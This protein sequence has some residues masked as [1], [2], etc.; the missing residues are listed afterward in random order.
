MGPWTYHEYYLDATND[1]WGGN[2]GA[3]MGQYDAIPAVGL[4]ALTL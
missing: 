4:E 1:P 2:Y 3:L